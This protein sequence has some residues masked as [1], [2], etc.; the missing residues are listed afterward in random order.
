M[1]FLLQLF[2]GFFNSNPQDLFDMQADPLKI[3]LA[4]CLYLLIIFLFYKFVT[5]VFTVQKYSKWLFYAA[6][7]TRLLSIL[8]PTEFFVKVASVGSLLFFSGMA[9]CILIVPSTQKW[10]SLF[11]IG[12]CIGLLGI[13][14]YP[15]MRLG[16]LSLENPEQNIAYILVITF[17]IFSLFCLLAVLELGREHLDKLEKASLRNMARAFIQLR[18]LMNTP[19]Q[20][21]EI[22]IK[23]LQDRCPDEAPALQRMEKS[24]AV[25]R[26]VDTALAEYEQSVDWEHTDSFISV[27]PD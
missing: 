6:L 13:N 15:L 2:P 7:F 25:L 14:F 5:A 16:F 17:T 12:G 23:L 21:L 20:T 26:K 27:K 24:L 10:A 18:D 11:K 4:H 1:F 19:F 8:S 3:R 9:I 22:S